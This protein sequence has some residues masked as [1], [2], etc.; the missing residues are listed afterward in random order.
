MSH[1][2]YFLEIEIEQDFKTGSLLMRQIKFSCDILTRFNMESKAVRTPQDPGLKL[3]KFIC[4]GGCK[5]NERMAG[6]PY[7]NV[8]GC[9]MYLTAGT[10]RQ[11]AYSANLPQTHAQHTV[12]R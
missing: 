11:L 9:W 5:H 7:R 4:K 10:L 6:V 1:L 8:V 12:K 3:T 2:K